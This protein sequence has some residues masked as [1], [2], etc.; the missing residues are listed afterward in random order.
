MLKFFTGLFLFGAFLLGTAPVF[1][2]DDLS[3]DSDLSLAHLPNKILSDL[4]HIFIQ[5]NAI[6]FI[7]GS[8]L[9]AGDW[10]LLDSTNWPTS[11]LQNLNINPVWDFGNFY[12]EGWVEGLGGVG[13]WTIGAMTGDRRLAEFGRDA[14]ESLLL[15]TVTVTGL[16]YAVGRERPDGSNNQSFPSGHSITAFSFAPV[17][18]HYYGWGAGAAAYA[19][20]SVTGLARIEGNHHY[21]SDVIGGATL[22]ILIGNMVVYHPKDISLGL[23]PGTASVQLAFN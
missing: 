1:S 17:V 12:G 9:T 18:T 22:G 13:S 21:A 11:G 3:P 8:F 14:S 23:G 15:A 2:Q 19:L 10:V 6:P 4:P 5:E 7:T 20:A 16:K